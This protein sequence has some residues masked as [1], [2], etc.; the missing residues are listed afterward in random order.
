[1]ASAGQRDAELVGA[2][3]GA[4][5]ALP[6]QDAR[7]ADILAEL[8][9]EIA[10][11]SPLER[12]RALADEA[13]TLARAAEDPGLLCRVLVQHAFAI[14]VVHTIDERVTNL[15]E[16]RQLA[17]RVADPAL[18]FLTASRSCNVIEA[19]DLDGFDVQVARMRELHA[20]L[21]QPIMEWT[22][23]FTEAPRAMLEGRFSEVERLATRAFEVSGGTHDGLTI[24]GAQIAYVRWEQGRM[25]ELIDAMAQAVID[26]P[27]LPAFKAAHAAACCSA[28]DHDHARELLESLAADD[29]ASMPLDL[30]WSGMLA[31][32]S[33][34]AFRVGATD[35]AAALYRL[36][37]P[38]ERTIIWNGCILY[39]PT[40]RHLGR[41]ALM[42]ERYDE[43]E[44]H[45][46]AA[47]AEHE[48]IG[49]PVWQADTDRLMGLTLLRRPSADAG[50]AGQLLR[51][52]AQTAHEYGAA[53]I[54]R[55]AQE[56]LADLTHRQ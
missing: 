5:E 38:H 33:E 29:S 34:V 28:G 39:G 13:L 40:A 23:L 41:L 20:V 14:W 2:L 51:R 45:L 8:A 7:R 19:G 52:A 25:H 46:A 10:S 43:A 48:R 9:A 53:G 42:L 17:D 47:S 26:N 11:T 4:A 21:G 1:M 36:L 56:A 15:D 49:A 35:T 6:T 37:L 50:R 54:E 16:A 3:E 30:S 12:R 32:C 44:A 22:L 27:A 55:E 18:Q 24:F 31:L